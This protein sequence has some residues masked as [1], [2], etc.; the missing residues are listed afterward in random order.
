MWNNHKTINRT[1]RIIKFF[2]LK[3]LKSFFIM[4]IFLAILG[5][6]TTTIRGYNDKNNN[7]DSITSNK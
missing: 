7:N 5:T 3:L 4:F 1:S 2:I 6:I